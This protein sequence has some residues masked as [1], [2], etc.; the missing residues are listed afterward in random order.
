MTRLYVILLLICIISCSKDDP[1]IDPVE[2]PQ[3]KPLDLVEMS[4]YIGSRYVDI[5][6]NFDQYNPKIKES[7]G[8]KT[9]ELGVID[10]KANFGSFGCNI[11]EKNGYIAEIDISDKFGDHGKYRDL[12]LYFDGIISKNF[13]LSSVAMV[14]SNGDAY[15]SARTKEAVY[16]K[17]RDNPD[18][19]A[20]FNFSNTNSKLSLF[21]TNKN[22]YS[23]LI[24]IEKK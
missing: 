2:L 17:W 7:L 23:F 10:S 3:S 8:D 19:G 4:G 18:W 13:S 6:T 5:K 16:T 20:L 21:C 9:I 12:F 22:D 15:V 14:Q 24:K 11:V 1:K